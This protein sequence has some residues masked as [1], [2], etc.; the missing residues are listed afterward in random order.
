MI[1]DELDHIREEQEAQTDHCKANCPE[2]HDHL[3]V[4]LTREMSTEIKQSLKDM[5]KSNF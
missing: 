4:T 3:M 5:A 1:S 2:D